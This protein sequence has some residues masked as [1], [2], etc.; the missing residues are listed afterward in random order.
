MNLGRELRE[1]TVEP[2]EWPQPT[3]EPA[4]E[5]PA[6]VPEPVEVEAA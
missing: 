5:A 3:R 6:S 2:V 1:L 4:K